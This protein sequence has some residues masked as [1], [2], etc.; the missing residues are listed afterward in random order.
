MKRIICSLLA[1]CCFI[2]PALAERASLAEDANPFAPYVLSAP[3]GAA[4]EEGEG[5][6]TFVRENTRVVAQVISRVPD[7]D[8]AEAVLRMMTQFEPFAIIGEDLPTAEGFVAVTAL[9]E[10]K[11]GDG[12]DMISVMVLSCE[13]DLMILSAYDLTGETDKA[14]ALLDALLETLAVS[15]VNIIITEE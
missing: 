15:D 13:G 14:Q 11:F 7:A 1:I 8:P 4:L 12:V 2:L 5:S 10:D 9:N 6:L 3:E